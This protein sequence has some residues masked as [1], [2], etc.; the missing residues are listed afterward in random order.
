MPATY[1]GF[2]LRFLY[3]ENWQ[4]S[5]EQTDDAWSVYVQ[6]PGTGFVQVIGHRGRPSVEEMLNSTIAAL[7]EDYPDLEVEAVGERIAGRSVQGRD[8][9][10][11]SLDLITTCWLRCFRT[12]EATL[13]ILCQVHDQEADQLEPV[14]RA[15]R[16]S[17]Q[18]VN[19]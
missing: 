3:P 7:Q 5:E 10:F 6:S 12:P 14:F 1:E 11:I 16:R 8:V 13:M 9:R 19:D 18:L 15:L 17:L 2:G 4:I